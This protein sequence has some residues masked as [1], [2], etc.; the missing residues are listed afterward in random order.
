MNN[1]SIKP[2]K[3]GALI[4]LYKN[5]SKYGFITLSSSEMSVG[6]DGWVRESSRSTLMRAEVPLL[7]KFVASSKGL[8][9]PGKIVVNEFMESQIPESYSARL[10]KN[11]DYETSINP[12]IKRAGKEG[13]ELTLGG[14]RIL[15]F[16]SYDPSGLSQDARVAHDNISEVTAS[17]KEMSAEADL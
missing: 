14:E 16:T 11:V 13:V 3:D 12:Y 4:T 2:S 7:E 5:N 6:A 1:V 9:L 8:T 10:N 15:R 17:K